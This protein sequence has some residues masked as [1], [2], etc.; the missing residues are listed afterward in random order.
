M[1]QPTLTEALE[2]MKRINDSSIYNSYFE[3]RGDGSVGMIIESPILIT[4]R[5][6]K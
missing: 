6:V 5:R 1:K 3:G 4:E 2:L